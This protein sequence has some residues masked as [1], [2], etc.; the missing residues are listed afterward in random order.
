MQIV[1]QTHITAFPLLARGK[2][3]DIYGVDENTLL[4]VTTDRMSAFDVIMDRPIPYRGV[5][6]NKIS[7]FW[8]DRL[9]ALVPNHVL[10]RNVDKFPAAL[11]PWRDELEGRALLV[12]K[13]EPLPLECIV[14]GFLAGS[15][16][17][18]Y[19]AT[20]RLRGSALPEGLEE[21][22]RLAPPL[23]TPSTKAPQ[24]A[25]DE[26]IS[27][28]EGA[29]L[30]GREL[31]AEV[32]RLSLTLFEAGS[33]YAESRGIL[34]ADTKFEFGL[35]RGKLLLIDEVMTPD[36]SRFWPA[37]SYR[38]G[39]GQTSFDKQYLRDWLE[40]SSWDKKAPPPALPD[41]VVDVTTGKYRK[42]YELLTG[43]PFVV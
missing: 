42:A 2:V 36:S 13:A 25:H 16:W 26:N 28:E 7:L 3:R 17:K 38:P 9:A 19:A 5:I 35:V 30:A 12:R 32:R 31:F 43:T 27:D 37:E 33:A 29:A 1:T 10:E 41:E 20:G 21:S 24:G 8:M 18:E 4:I 23:F 34:V 15:A 6:L 40:A 14:R 22:A 39:R 11:A